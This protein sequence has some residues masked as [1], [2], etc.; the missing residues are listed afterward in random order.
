MRFKLV[1]DLFCPNG[2]C[3][4]PMSFDGSFTLTC[5]CDESKYGIGLGIGGAPQTN[6]FDC[7][8]IEYRV[9]RS[10]NAIRITN[11]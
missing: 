8:A 2:F 1:Y 10:G 3:D 4:E 5:S 9:I 7:P 11:F 6:G